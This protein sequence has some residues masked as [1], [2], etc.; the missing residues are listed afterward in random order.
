MPDKLPKASVAY[1]CAPPIALVN[2][3]CAP[4]IAPVNN[5]CACPAT[6]FST[7]CADPS[8]LFNNALPCAQAAATG[9]VNCAA[10]LTNAPTAPFTAPVAA[11]SVPEIRLF[12]AAVAP[13]LSPEIHWVTV[14]TAPLAMVDMLLIGVDNKLLT[15]AVALAPKDVTPEKDEVISLLKSLLKA[16]VPETNEAAVSVASPPAP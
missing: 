1:P 11:P 3:P 16:A 12:A 4:P 6:L 10:L 13:V 14:F 9:A 7:P 15:V 8:V 2:N 5:P